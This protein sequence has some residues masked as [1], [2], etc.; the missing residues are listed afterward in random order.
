MLIS[1]SAFYEGFQSGT[2]EGKQGCTLL[3]IAGSLSESIMLGMQL[4]TDISNL[5][6]SRLQRDAETSS[7]SSSRS[8]ESRSSMSSS[9]GF[10]N[11]REIERPVLGLTGLSSDLKDQ[12]TSYLLRF[13]IRQ[14]N[15]CRTTPH[16]QVS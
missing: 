3:Q 9:S 13:D 6:P 8:S 10:S 4:V 15:K 11:A 12:F 5:L 16:M 1:R 2:G 7:A 14:S